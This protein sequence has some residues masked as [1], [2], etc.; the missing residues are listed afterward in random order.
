MY[1]DTFVKLNASGNSGVVQCIS[2][3]A[4]YRAKRRS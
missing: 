1:K 2:D 3:F 4:D